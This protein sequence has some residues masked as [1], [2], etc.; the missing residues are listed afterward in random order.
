MIRSRHQAA[1]PG[2][3]G[4]PPDPGAARAMEAVSRLAGGIAHDLNNI[5]L[6]V[7]GYAEMAL[8]EKDAG[9]ETRAHLGEVSAAAARAAALVQDL[10]VVGRRSVV[11][12]APVDVNA[13]IDGLLPSLRAAAGSALDVRFT[14]G[15]GVPP[16]VADAVQLGRAAAILCARAVEVMP[17][18]GSIELATMAVPGPDGTGRVVLAVTDAG[19][20]LPD[21]L[22]EHLFEPYYAEPT[23]GK[24]YGLRLSLVHGIVKRLGGD[25]EVIAGPGGGTTFLLSL[26]CRQCSP[27]TVAAASPRE[28]P[29]AAATPAPRPASAGPTILVAEDEEPLRHLAVKILT[30]EGY[31]VLEARDGQEALEIFE[32]QGG[33]IRLAV[34]D[35]VMPRLGGRA[36]LA[37]MRQKAPSLPA[38]LCSGYT[39]SFDGKGTDPVERCIV[40]QKPWQARELLRCLREGLDGS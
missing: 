11:Q 21:R 37:R 7:Q 24:G 15:S 33:E 10:L 22:R 30:R 2:A 6:V 20:P 16:I 40:L 17:A 25:V 38:V 19:T 14:P 36:A 31:A 39:W 23:A 8:A 34:L 1:P 28:A 9:P 29:A 3:P 5:L 26:P 13:L 27:D 12:P 32:R 35:D 18:G 4:A